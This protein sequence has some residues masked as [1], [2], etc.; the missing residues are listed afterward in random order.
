MGDIAQILGVTTT[1]DGGPP[2]PAPAAPPR[3][4]K[5][6]GL[7]KDVVDLLGTTTSSNN[8]DGG[9]MELPTSVPA[10][11]YRAQQLD[12]KDAVV[13]VGNMWIS[14]SKPARKWVW[15]PFSSSARTD[16]LLLHHWVRNVEYPDYPYARFDIHL[17]PVT[18]NTD[19]EYRTYL[20]DP[21]W[22][23]GETDQLLELAKR[24]EL[25]WPVIYDRWI[26]LFGH[27]GTS[28]MDT[29][30]HRKI[31]DLQHR[32]YSVAA[33]LMQTRISH[34]AAAEALSLASQT[35][36]TAAAAA[37]AETGIEDSKRATD[38]LLVETAAARAL[39]TADPQH[40]PVM[41]NIGSGTSNKVV[42]DLNYE[43]ERRSHMEALWNRTKEE[44]IE[45]AELRKELKL[46]EA[47]LRKM[48]K[49]G[50]HIL[51]AGGALS[52]AASS[53]NP[54]RAATPVQI[55]GGIGSGDPAA[56]PALLDQA[57][58][59]TAPTAAAGTPY[60]QSGR[61]LPPTIGG[62]AGINKTLR[63]RM[64]E[65]LEEM[66]I[67]VNPLPTKRVCDLYDTV[68][69]DILTLLVIQKT[70]LQKEGLLASKR[71]KLAKR[72]GNVRVVDEETLLGIAPSQPASTTQS[73][74]ARTGAKVARG[75]AKTGKTG[76]GSSGKIKGTAKPKT[77]VDPSAVRVEVKK[78][79]VTTSNAVKQV[80]AST[81]PGVK[82]IRKP[83]APGT[84]RNRKSGDTDQKT[85]LPASATTAATTGTAPVVAVAV[86]QVQPDTEAS[87]AVGQ[88][89]SQSGA[90]DTKPPSKKRAKKSTV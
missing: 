84:K 8:W 3:A 18:Y 32:Y 29:P 42:F 1:N 68:R 59:T 10:S 26:E 40:Q 34:E 2:P 73:L 41:H 37:T 6:Q 90:G 5:L 28:D 80:P 66:G 76:T 57:F 58:A 63:N 74:G 62:T 16:G 85:L 44:E 67:S 50:A 38:A 81:T 60:L 36:A 83:A 27:N 89:E 30:R 72:G 86:P 79:T 35:A 48:K 43:R 71:L 9:A 7:P 56:V 47:Q 87:A 61:L 65:V 21:D 88:L 39:A 24:F 15:A 51:A 53:K 82:Q 55:G 14:A 45:E 25:R 54:S 31:E 17:D 23:K 11:S 19:E 49:S 20:Q 64:D 12:K 33:I 22:S 70:A 77:A 46:V 69:K 13:K 52:S 75:S 4:M 78:D